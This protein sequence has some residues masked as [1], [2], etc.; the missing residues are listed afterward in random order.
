MFKDCTEILIER[1]KSLNALAKTWSDYKQPNTIKIL[2]GISQ[3][4]FI[5][6]VSACNGGRNNAALKWLLS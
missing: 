5:I 6:F 2:I 3:N 4:G 1:P